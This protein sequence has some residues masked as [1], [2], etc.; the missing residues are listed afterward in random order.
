M[1]ELDKSTMDNII[2]FFRVSPSGRDNGIACCN[3]RTNIAW[4]QMTRLAMKRM[5]R[6]CCFGDLLFMRD[7]YDIV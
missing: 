5:L 3:R 7:M 6:N 4:R 2:S 1:Q